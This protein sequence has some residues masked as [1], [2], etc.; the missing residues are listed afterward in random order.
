[1]CSPIHRCTATSYARVFQ[2][3]RQGR[4]AA[5]I[6]NIAIPG[7]LIHGIVQGEVSEEWLRHLEALHDKLAFVRQSKLVQARPLPGQPEC[8]M[9]LLKQGV[10]RHSARQ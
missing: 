2:L 5:F 3:D 7:P 1:M 4:L 6:D 10:Q 8:S 9:L